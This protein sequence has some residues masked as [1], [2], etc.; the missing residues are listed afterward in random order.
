MDDLIA[1]IKEYLNILNPDLDIDTD[2]LNFVIEETL[3]RVQLYLNNDTIPEKLARIL[4]SVINTNLKKVV[5][6][7]EISS[8]DPTEV[9]QVITS[10]SDNGQSISYANE[11]KQYFSTV[12]DNELFT[13]FTNLLSR[14]RRI[15]VVYP[16]QD[17]E[18]DS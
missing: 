17:E 18:E 8:E 2:T 3:D 16:K 14:Y 6:E 7:Q 4:A 11:V 10:I 13:G 12:S 15:K 5:K 1:K 9:D